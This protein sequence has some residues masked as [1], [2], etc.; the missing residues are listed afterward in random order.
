VSAPTTHAAS[1]AAGPD[2]LAGRVALV[3][4]AGSGIGRA[5]ALAFAA[6]GAA[7]VLAGRRPD[8]LDE[9]AHAIAAAGGTAIAVATDVAREADVM[10]LVARAVAR[11]GRLDCAFNNAGVSGAS[12]PLHQGEAA[13]FD[14][15]IGTNLRGAWLCLKHVLAAMRAAGLDG[16]VRGGAIVN[17]SSF[18]AH[19]AA[20]RT[21]IYAASKAGLDAM[22]RVAAL[23]AGPYGIRVNSV[24][25]GA[26]ETPMFRGAGGGAVAER[27]TAHTPLGRLG[28]P[29]DVA[30]AAVWLCTDAARFIT[31]Q[32]LLV[33][34]GMT[35]PGVR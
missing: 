7:V 12:V 29:E 15:V 30:D 24:Q 33:D 5:A 1:A 8:A 22:T 20:P 4:G 18:L 28:R 27:L 9:T 21:A 35:L 11:F 32:A 23:E 10:A 3:T 14:R 31:G 25:P 16:R 13:E 34:G 2:A 26:I 17:T 6:H 19:G